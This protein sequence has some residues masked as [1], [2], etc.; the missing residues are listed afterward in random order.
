[1][2]YLK[3]M[4][5]KTNIAWMLKKR[6]IAMSK[7]WIFPLIV[8]LG[9]S[10]AQLPLT[11]DA[12]TSLEVVAISSSGEDI[13][14]AQVF[15]NG[16]LVGLTPFQ[17]ESI[18]PGLLSLRVVKTGF[19]FFTK[20]LLISEGQFYSVEAV[21]RAMPA[22][23]GELLV[24]TNRDSVLVTVQDSNNDTV[25]ETYER[26]SAHVLPAGAY[27]LSGEKQGFPKVV[28]T[29]DVVATKTTTVNLD[30]IAENQ[31]E[32]PTLEFSIVED[33]V[34]MG[35][36][37]NLKWN[38]DGYQVIIDQGVGTRGPN[39]SEKLVTPTPGMK[40]FTA[41]AYGD[42][43]L[44]TEKKDS[45][46][47]VPRTSTP[48]TLEFSVAQDSVMF[49][50]PALIQWNS[51]GYQVAIDH[52]VGVRGPAGSEEVYFNNPGKK[53]FT[54]IAYGEDNLLTTRKD[55]VFVKEAPIPPL[56]VIML[57]TTRRVTVNTPATITWHAQNAD[58]MVVDYVTNPDVQGSAE[59]TFSTPGIRI[60][61]ATAF[62][63]AGYASASDTI[64]V[65]EPEVEPVEDIILPAASSVRADKGESGYFDRN[66]ATFE[67]KT[68][69]RYRLFAEVWY[70][71]GDSQLNESFYVEIRDDA[72]NVN[73]PR[74]PNAG[75]HL[76]VADDP[77]EPHTMTRDCGVFIFDAGHHEID[78]IHYAK[79]ANQYPQ[80]LNGPIDGPESVKIL[81]FKLVYV[82][83]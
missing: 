26:I 79:I 15:L 8:A 24:S 38:S 65:V 20:Q 2:R 63:A 9:C 47:V 1:M 5:A 43:N 53:V 48:P 82:E 59:V 19:Q 78:V 41:T 6:G 11:S 83:E 51:D 56:P 45:V 17:K 60:V 50:E 72:N 57:S 30:L 75:I 31:D 61:T 71:S 55:S 54:A 74:D 12:N 34:Q 16:D 28:K 40:I 39:G 21:L 22:N 37:F 67:I 29:A 81:G 27:T 42:G 14:S 33:T 73:L 64:E 7:L 49:G 70:N 52:G 23:E 76:V 18:Q 69:G 46:Y 77:G 44:T 10:K 36:T 35:E 68:A 25:V 66:A 62:N 32:P 13:D 58:Y 4:E 3:A 80:F